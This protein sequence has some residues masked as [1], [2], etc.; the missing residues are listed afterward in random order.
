MTPSLPPVRNA[1]TALPAHTHHNA[2]LPNRT[3]NRTEPTLP[4]QIWIP[5][6]FMNFA[7]SPMW[8]RIPVVASTSLIWTI[9][10]SSMRGGSE[11]PVEVG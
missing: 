2:R 8:L 11:V 5:A 7:F 4:P 1:R 6:T 3:P 10:L 9:I